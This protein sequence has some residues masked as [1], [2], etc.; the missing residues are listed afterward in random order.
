[1]VVCTAMDM[2]ATITDT[3]TIINMVTVLVEDLMRL[4]I[5]RHITPLIHLITTTVVVVYLPI[6]L[7]LRHLQ[8]GRDLSIITKRC[9]PLRLL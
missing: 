7:L 2:E 6:M 4:L 9:R 5:L 8:R 1:M 3:N